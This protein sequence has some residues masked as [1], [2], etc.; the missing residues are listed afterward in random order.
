MAIGHTTTSSS[1][2]YYSKVLTVSDSPYTLKNDEDRFIGVDT[3]GG[4]IEIILPDI[5]AYPGAS[6]D[7]V[8]FFKIHN[9]N[10]ATFTLAVSSQTIATY[11]TLSVKIKGQGIEIV[12]NRDKDKYWWSSVG[13]YAALE[14][15]VIATASPLLSGTTLSLSGELLDLKGNSSVD[16]SFEYRQV[17]TSTW[18]TTTATTKT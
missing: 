17:G 8:T 15:P 3:A 12:R 2:L 4:N 18:S 16:C 14:T 10:K 5:S 9:E 11:S 7:L 6:V 13:A 1:N